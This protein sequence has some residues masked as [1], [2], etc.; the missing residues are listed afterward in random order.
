MLK[1]V[2]SLL[3]CCSLC[4]PMVC[5]AE[6]AAPEAAVT[7]EKKVYTLTLEEAIEIAMENNPQMAVCDYQKESYKY[8]LDAAKITKKNNKNTPIYASSGY[9]IGYIQE[10]Y[11]IDMYETQLKLADYNKEKTKAG[12]IYN[13]TTAYFNYK[14][15]EELTEI[16]REQNEEALANMETVKRMSELGMVSDVEMQNAQLAFDSAYNY[17]QSSLRIAENAKE[18]FKVLLDFEEDCDLTLTSEIKLPE[19]TADLEKDIESAM[20]TRCDVITLEEN[21]RLSEIHFKLTEKYATKNT[22]AYYS[23]LS[24]YMSNK[25][26]AENSIKLIKVAIK[27]TYNDVLTAK[28]NLVT[29][30][31]KVDIQK[32]LYEAAK[33]KFNMG[34]ITNIELTEALTDYAMA[35]EEYE[36]V[37]LNYLLAV[38]K[39]NYDVT[40]GL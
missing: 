27:Q 8:G 4:L 31:R 3:V 14:I 10:G 9:E 21:L 20:T 28:D 32:T 29:S 39:Y 23:D 40:I 17:L 13:I 36:R 38:E 6:E 30:Q 5:M 26:N 37:K 16:A 11:Y 18:T 34:M 33:V 24:T 1:K 7:T 15:L 22:A 12:I 25:Q 2:I 19:F 35:E